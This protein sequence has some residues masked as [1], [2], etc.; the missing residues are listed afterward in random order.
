[1]PKNTKIYFVSHKRDDTL[2]LTSISTSCSSPLSP[3]FAAAFTSECNPAEGIVIHLETDLITTS[4]VYLEFIDG[5]STNYF[6]AAESASVTQREIFDIMLSNCS[7][8]CDQASP[9]VLLDP[10]FTPVQTPIFSP[11]ANE[12][13]FPKS[14]PLVPTSQPQLPSFP[15][16][17]LR[18][19]TALPRLT[20]DPSPKLLQSSPGPILRRTPSPIRGPTL[21]ITPLPTSGQDLTP[22]AHHVHM[23]QF[24]PQCK[25]LFSY[26]QL[27]RRSCQTCN[28]SCHLCQT[29]H[30]RNHCRNYLQLLSHHHHPQHQK[31]PPSLLSDQL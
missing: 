17:Q 16:S 15:K 2:Q 28:Q 3:P 26:R 19:P 11:T 18:N 23:T 7:C 1:M 10:V 5:V 27:M 20:P 29:R 13:G 24:Q 31:K 12:P 6:L 9:T 8:G 30:P 21:E 4:Q 25:V 22:S 14:Q